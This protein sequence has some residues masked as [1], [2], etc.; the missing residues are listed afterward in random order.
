MA[1]GR[2]RTGVAGGWHG[3]PRPG[4]QHCVGGVML[5]AD[6]GAWEGVSD[7]SG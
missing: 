4:P 7:G 3:G 6:V 1:S 5:L 2:G